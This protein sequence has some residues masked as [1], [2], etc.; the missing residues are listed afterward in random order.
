MKVLPYDKY[1]IK[2]KEF[3]KKNNFSLVDLIKKEKDYLDG[4]KFYISDH[5]FPIKDEIEELIES[6]KGKCVEKALKDCIVIMDK[7]N[8]RDQIK[9]LKSKNF[10]IYTVDLVLESVFEQSL[11][12]NKAKYKL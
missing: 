9:T 8:D 2:D 1:Y 10:K 4:Y 5:V 3:E 6:A 11:D 7:N 12:L